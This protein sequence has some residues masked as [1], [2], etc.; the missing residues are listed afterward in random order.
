MSKPSVSKIK[1][2]NFRRKIKEINDEELNSRS[3]LKSLY[4]QFVLDVGDPEMA[5]RHVRLAFF[6][7]QKFRLHQQLAER[8]EFHPFFGASPE[9][10]HYFRQFEEDEDDDGLI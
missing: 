4:D 6:Q 2:R 3:R 7:I 9:S 5:L 10:S 1:I 8:L